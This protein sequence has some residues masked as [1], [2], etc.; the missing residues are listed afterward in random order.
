MT[1]RIHSSMRNRNGLLSAFRENPPGV[2]S[3][4]HHQRPPRFPQEATG[5]RT[6]ATRV[7]LPSWMARTRTGMP[8]WKNTLRESLAVA[9]KKQPQDSKRSPLWEKQKLHPP[10]TT[11]NPL[12][13][14]SR[15]VA[16]SNPNNDK[17]YE[18]AGC[19]R[20]RQAPEPP[21]HIT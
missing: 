11:A 20:Q 10:I 9:T 16:T 13:P 2:L 17:T 6:Q 5:R 19:G 15:G 12:Q 1:V 4:G 7:G 3:V 14:R 21:P 8:T 18:D